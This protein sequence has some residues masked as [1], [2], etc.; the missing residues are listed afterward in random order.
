MLDKCHAPG[1]FNPDQ[2]L[3]NN[4]LLGRKKEGFGEGGRKEFKNMKKEMEWERK[5]QSEIDLQQDSFT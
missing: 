1:S 2:S 4:I 3:D 5:T